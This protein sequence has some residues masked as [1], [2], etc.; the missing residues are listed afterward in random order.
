MQLIYILVSLCLVAGLLSLTVNPVA[1]RASSVA[2][3]KSKP[4][5]VQAIED[6]AQRESISPDEVEVVSAEEVVWPDTSMGCPH[7]DMRYPQV[8]QDGMRII[9]RA[10]GREYA[11]HSGGHRAPFLCDRKVSLQKPQKPPQIHLA[12]G[13][14]NLNH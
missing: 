4:L 6:L 3:L 2:D 5:V 1:T 8:L 11:Y 9:L 12:P 13:P 7:P 14:G 10:N